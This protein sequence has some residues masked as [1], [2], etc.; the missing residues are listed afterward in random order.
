MGS[1]VPA[2]GILEPTVGLR[3]GAVLVVPLLDAVGAALDGAGV[4]G[5]TGRS[6][7]M[8]VAPVGTWVPLC[9]GL[10]VGG[11]DGRGVTSSVVSVGSNVGHLVG[12]AV[13]IASSVVVCPLTNVQ[14]EN[15][16]TQIQNNRAM[17]LKTK[18]N[19]SV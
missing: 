4:G 9:V 3:V 8:V 1:S 2:V 19:K 5:L 16:A 12:E 15:T 11:R 6:S 10:L 7:L 13:I 14:C 18:I 17:R